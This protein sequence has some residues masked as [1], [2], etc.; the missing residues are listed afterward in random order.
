[1]RAWAAYRVDGIPCPHNH[2]TPAHA[3]RCLHHL[4]KVERAKGVLGGVW[5]NGSVDEVFVVEHPE[6]WAP[7]GC[8]QAVLL[9]V[10][11]ALL[12]AL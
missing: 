8:V 4:R 3:A 5:A 2:P 11:V 6:P 7:S 10:T 1:M 12:M 9:L